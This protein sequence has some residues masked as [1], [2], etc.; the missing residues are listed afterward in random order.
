MGSMG[1]GQLMKATGADVSV[2]AVEGATEG[3]VVGAADLHTVRRVRPLR[4]AFVGKPGSGKDTAAAHFPD[5]IVVRFAGPV[6]RIASA[7]QTSVGARV[8]KDRDLLRDI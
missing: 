1:C 7:Y 4:L 3:A 6:Y 5:A 8:R 2:G